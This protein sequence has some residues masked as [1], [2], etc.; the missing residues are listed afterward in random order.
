M[1][2]KNVPRVQTTSVVVWTPCRSLPFV[3]VVRCKLLVTAIVGRLSFLSPPSTN[4]MINVELDPNGPTPFP[5]LSSLLPPPTAGP[6][7][8][9]LHQAATRTEGV[10]TVVNC[11]LG[12]R[13]LF[14]DGCV[15]VTTT[16]GASA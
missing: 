10:Q 2:N 11:H 8:E 3:I 13:Y 15:G 6:M 14:S 4:H 1:I 16:T 12:N 9:N 7:P 5:E